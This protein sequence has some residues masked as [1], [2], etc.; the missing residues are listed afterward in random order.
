MWLFSS[1]RK[2]LTLLAQRDFLFLMPN[3]KLTGVRQRAA[4]GPE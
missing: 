4:A 1:R 3:V 2:A